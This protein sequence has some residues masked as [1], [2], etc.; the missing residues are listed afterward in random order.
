MDNFHAA[1]TLFHT[2]ILQIKIN[3][4]TNALNEASFTP[5]AIYIL[6]TFSKQA[7]IKGEQLQDYSEL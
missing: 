6:V 2:G 1:K 5:T 4:L 7:S 3:C